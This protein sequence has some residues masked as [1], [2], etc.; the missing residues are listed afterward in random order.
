MR[1]KALESNM[2]TFSFFSILR[3]IAFVHLEFQIPRAIVEEKQM[4]TLKETHEAEKA[5]ALAVIDI[6]AEGI[7]QC[8]DKVSAEL[9]CIKY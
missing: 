3:L 6:F 5:Q 2:L 9:V 4:Q 1:A 8:V 7:S